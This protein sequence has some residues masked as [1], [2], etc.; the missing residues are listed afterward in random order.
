[1]ISLRRQDESDMQSCPLG[2]PIARFRRVIEH[3]KSEREW[4]WPLFSRLSIVLSG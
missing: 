2:Q 3:R 1:V 4:I